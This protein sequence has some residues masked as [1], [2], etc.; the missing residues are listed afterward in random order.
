MCRD[1]LLQAM[2]Q[3]IL[4]GHGDGDDDGVSGENLLF[5]VGDG[6]CYAP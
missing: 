1:I 5:G 3:K 2:C 4:Q 6:V